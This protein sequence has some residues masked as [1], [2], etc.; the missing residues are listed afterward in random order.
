[1]V[2][3]EKGY[4]T[5]EAPVLR[6]VNCLYIP[7]NDPDMLHEWFNQVFGLNHKGWTK[8]ANGLT[9]IFVKSETSGRL[10]FEGHWDGKTD[11]KMYVMQFEVENAEALHRTLN[12]GGI[13]VSHLRDNGGCGLEFDFYD[14]EGN[15]YCAWE[16][17]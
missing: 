14:P 9:L 3:E 16:S 4:N 13:Q 10:A 7:A 17:R 6:K 1:M 15:R 11:F 5:P 2:E 12:E 8:L